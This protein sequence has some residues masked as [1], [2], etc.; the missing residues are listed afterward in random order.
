MMILACAN[1]L[2]A[3][4]LHFSQFMH[5]PLTT[6]PANTGFIPDADFRI[7]ANYRTQWSSVMTLPYKT[8][9]VFAD[10]QIMRDKL[11]N[12]WL[13]LGGVLLND[14][15]GAGSL[16]ST[17]VY[18]SIAY[19]QM[20]GYSSL[21][22]AGF[23]LGYAQ[24]S[25]D[26]SK[27][28]FPDQFN[29]KFFENN[30]PTTA[31]IDR[32]SIN[33]FDLQAGV[34]YAYF[35][36][37]NTYIN[38]G[39]SIH[40]VNK[41]KE[42]FLSVPGELSIVP[43]RHIAFLNGIIKVSERVILRPNIY[44]TNQA[45]ASEIVG[46]ALADYNINAETNNTQFRAGLYYRHKDAIVPMAGFVVGSVAFTASQDVTIS[47]MKK[48]NHSRGATEFSIIKNGFYGQKKDRQTLCPTF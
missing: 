41:P 48:F 23:N 8:F 15:A 30:I 26:N 34:N 38:A 12:G 32:P 28:I 33:Y 16:K 46:G 7:G 18:A 37:E 44:Y 5:S 17:K 24:K 27:L 13:G 22:S 10:A 47:G 36:T 21:L 19:H 20:L 40:H 39:Y 43:L 3:Q 14:V 42:S 6:N 9:S 4:D 2:S 11:E 45:S 1:N 25:I 31:I 29:G 35:P